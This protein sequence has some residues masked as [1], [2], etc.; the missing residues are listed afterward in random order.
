[1]SDNSDRFTQVRTRS[2]TIPD[3]TQVD[4]L[5]EVGHEIG[6]TSGFAIFGW[7]DGDQATTCT[8]VDILVTQGAVLARADGQAGDYPANDSAQSRSMA[9]AATAYQLRGAADCRRLR[10]TATGG[11]AVVAVTTLTGAS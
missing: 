5:R 8:G 4:V 11:D 9:A 3:G 7:Q 6:G 10:I 2:A 1:M